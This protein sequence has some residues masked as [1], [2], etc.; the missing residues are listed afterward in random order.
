MSVIA[1]MLL[2]CAMVLPVCAADGFVPSI[3]YKDNPDAGEIK[4][5]DGDEKVLHELDSEC[6]EI[7]PVSDAV[8]TPE[9]ERSDADKLLVEVYEKLTD[10]SMKLPY[11]GENTENM[12]IRDLIDASLICGNVHTDP[13][14]V[15]ELAKP[16]VYIEIVFD[17]GV[18]ADTKVVVMAYVDGK[19]APIYKV[20]NLGD[21]RVRCV[22][23]EI[24]PIAFCVDAEADNTQTGDTIGDNLVLWIVLLVVALMAIVALQVVRRKTSKNKR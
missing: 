18:D 9:D 2:C 3:S 6:L 14:H 13:N 21:G 12:V 4:L 19:W 11:E 17:L 10:G 22:F 15:D 8:N 16:D 23:D 24:C 7:T 1:A 5:V 20:E